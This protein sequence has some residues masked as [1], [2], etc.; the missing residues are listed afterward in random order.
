MSSVTSPRV[1]TG[2]GQTGNWA[3][4]ANWD[5][6]IAPTADAA[7]LIPVSATLNGSFT[8]RI[9]MLLG[10]ETV[11]LNGALTTTSP[12]LCISF[13]VC[14]GATAV[15][16]P[17]ASLHDAGGIV[18]G[19]DQNGVLLAQGNA[20]AHAT[21]TTVSGKLGLNSGSSGTATLSGAVWNNSQ[22]FYAGL[23]GTGSLTVNNSGALNVGTSFVVGCGTKSS[24]TVAIS[25]GG[26][27]NVGTYAKIGGGDLSI[28]GGT[29]TVSV[30]TGGTFSVAGPLKIASTSSL[31]LSGG[32]V[33]A[34]DTAV[35]LQVWAD[36][37]LSGY[38]TVNATGFGISD[39]GTIRAAGGTLVL[40][41]NI[42]GTGQMQ[43]A[44][45]S[46]IKI[47]GATIGHAT[48]AF[49]G[50]NATLS[51]A[52]GATSQATLTGFAAGDS[53]V[54]PG[55]DAFSWNGTT[56]VLTLSSAGHAVETLQFNGTYGTNPF[57]LTQ[58]TAGAVIA[59]SPHH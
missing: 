31:V 29:G 58:T 33:N 21:L 15:F 45:T 25:A 19:A 34:P 7:V 17:T 36:G 23:G 5:G 1:Y 47:T 44:D 4:R 38:G 12:G 27:V 10:Q 46:T 41:G 48:I 57:A 3:D 49:T 51:L 28:V 40:N 42:S 20:T 52:H 35:G 2:H 18:V 6:T 37:T 54:M 14:N 30:A 50:H 43:I 32:T 9:A 55:I 8:A 13:M 11:T 16:T 53:I 26:Q 39:A 24:G 59:F 56:D 22:N